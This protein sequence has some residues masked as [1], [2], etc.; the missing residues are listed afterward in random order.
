VG[1]LGLLV[2][3]A[4]GAALAK[5]ERPDL[6]VAGQTTIDPDYFVR[7]TGN[8]FFTGRVKNRGG[9]T[10]K[11]SETALAFLHPPQVREREIAS[12]ETD[13]LKPGKSQFVSGGD[14]VPDLPPGA[15]DAIV[16]ADYKKKVK[17]KNEDNNCT[18]LGQV[19]V[20]VGSWFGTLSGSG[21]TAAG[22]STT[23]TWN[24]NDAELRFTE[25]KGDGRM[26][27]KFF[28]SLTYTI[29][30]TGSDDCEYSGTDTTAVSGTSPGELVLDYRKEEYFGNQGIGDFPFSWR[31][32]CDG[33]FQDVSPGP[34][35][36]AGGFIVV[37]P[38]EIDIPPLPFGS[39][40]LTGS[41][42]EENNGSQFGWLFG[43]GN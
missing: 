4:P 39:T 29:S 37:N 14:T 33:F 15:Y 8:A 43:A 19:Y 6:V 35:S 34:L 41:T 2:L 3:F 32:V 11:K 25:N 23:E 5:D 12:R 1:I 28:G 21:P 10:A 9:A 20:I 31:M 17:E 22:G 24:S 16:C 38:Q 42:V 36:V 7:G 30:G 40:S 18:Q 13:K 27:Y 26:A